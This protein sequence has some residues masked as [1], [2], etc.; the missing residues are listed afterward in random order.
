MPKP[1][2]RVGRVARRALKIAAGHESETDLQIRIVH[3]LRT[4]GYARRFFHCPNEGKRSKAY[5]ATLARMGLEAGI[6]D[7]VFIALN[8]WGRPSMLE[9]KIPGGVVTPPEEDI[10][11]RANLDGWTVGVA[12]SFEDALETLRTWG[13]AV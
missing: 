4:H 9:L 6:L 3:H 5:A 8:K 13:Y 1:P 11:R 7:L 10:M 12:Y 2:D